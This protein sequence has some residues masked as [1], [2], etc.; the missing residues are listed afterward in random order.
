[1][2]GGSIGGDWCYDVPDT[3]TATFSATAQAACE[4][5]YT[6]LCYIDQTD[7]TTY[8]VGSCVGGCQACAYVERS[9]G[10]WHC[11]A[12]TDV[13]YGCPFAVYEL[14]T[15]GSA[16]LLAADLPQVSRH[17]QPPPNTPTP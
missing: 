8:M 6:D 4:G 11:S 5:H 10:A 1:M 16:Y 13:V 3:A 14:A 12:A 15:A 2:P 7:A 9:D 17:P